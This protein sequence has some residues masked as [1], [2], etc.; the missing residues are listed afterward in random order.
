MHNGTQCIHNKMYIKGLT[1]V[2]LK[3][4]FTLNKIIQIDTRE[5]DDE[6]QQQQ[7]QKN[8]SYKKALI[9][10]LK[11]LYNKVHW[12]HART[13]T[14]KRNIITNGE[15]TWTWTW[16]Q[17]REFKFKCNG[18]VIISNA[19]RVYVIFFFVWLCGLFCSLSMFVN[20]ELHFNETI[21]SGWKFNF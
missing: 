15:W 21:R 6:Q 12:K 3:S 18:F 1:R 19:I 7:Q 5:D 2:W 20:C 14:H 17:I 9:R 11:H 8:T 13:C 4:F 16:T 10:T